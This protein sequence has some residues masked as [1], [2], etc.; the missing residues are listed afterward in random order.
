MQPMK[1]SDLA[2]LPTV[3]DITT[4]ARALGLSRTYAYHLAKHDNFPCKV[5]RIGTSY[6]VPA[7]ALLDLLDYKRGPD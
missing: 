4:A 1:Y 7:A 2:D 3:V 5:I 6:R